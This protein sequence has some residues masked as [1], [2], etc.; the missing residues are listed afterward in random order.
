[1]VRIDI[2]NALQLAPASISIVVGFILSAKAFLM[3]GVEDLAECDDEEDMECE[4][5]DL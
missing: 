2:H 4:S 5:E 1:M 3:W